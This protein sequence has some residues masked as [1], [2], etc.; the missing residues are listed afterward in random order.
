MIV[1]NK[2]LTSA[3]LGLAL[4]YVMVFNYGGCGG[5]GGGSSAPAGSSTAYATTNPATNITQSSAT[6][7]GMINPNGT[8]TN[9]YFE[10]G[11]SIGYGYS[12]AYQNTGSGGTTPVNVTANI[13]GLLPNT[14]YNFRLRATTAG[15]S[16]IAYNGANR[17][18]TTRDQNRSPVLATIGN[19][20]VNEGALLT[21]VISATDPDGDTMTYSA[22]NM[23]TGANF[24]TTTKTF[25]WTPNYTQAA[26]YSIT[27]NVFDNGI[28]SLSDNEQI[29]IT[30]NN[31]NGAPVLATIGNKTVN[32]GSL[33]TFTV[34]AADP[35]G[36]T[37]TYSATN[38][39]TGANLNSASGVFSWT[40]T[41]S[42]AGSFPNITFTVTDNGSP[43]LSDSEQITITVNNINGAPILATIGNKIGDAGVLL[44]FTISATDP[45]GDT[46]TYSA[47]NLPTGASFNP[48]TRTFSWT[49]STGQ[50]DTNYIVTFTATDNGSPNLSASKTIT[51]SIGDVNR[52]PDLVTIGNQSVNEGAL[53]T[54]TIS[55]TDPDTG[56]TLTYSATGLPTGAVFT[57]TTRTFSWTPSYTQS[58]SYPNVTFRVTDNGTPNL[59]AEEIITITVLNVNGA[60]VLAAIG[61]QTVNE[62]T[63][64]TFTISAADSDAGD[65]LT[66]SASNL[67]TGASFTQATRTFSWT[68]DYTQAGSYPNVT[69]TVTDNGTPNLSDFEQITI[70]VNNVNRAPVLTYIGDQTVNEGALLTFTISATDPDGNALTYSATNLP[71][72]ANL[73]SA[74]GVFSWTPTY[75]QAGS[76]PNVTFTVTDNGTSNL[77]DS[78]QIT[79]TVNNV[80]APTC[81][82]DAATNVAAT[83]ATLNGTVN[84]NGLNVSSCYFDYGTSTSYGSTS[85]ATPSPGSGT[86]NVSV[87]ANITS[88]SAGTL[89]N[90]RV[91]ATSLAGTTNGNNQTFTTIAPP[92]QV[93][94]SGR[95]PT[96]GATGVSITTALSW[97]SA[98]G[99]TS[100]NVYF[101]TDN[102]PSNIVNG[103]NTASTTYNPGTLTNSTTY[104]WRI[105]STN[106]GGTTAGIVWSFTTSATPPP[107]QVGSPSPSTGATGVSINPTLSWG[108]VSGAT[109][110]VYFGTNN[111]PS[112]IVNGTNTASTTYTP[113]ALANS[114]TYYWRI[115]STNAGGTT[116]GIVWSF[117]TAGS[118]TAVDNYLWVADYTPGNVIRLTKSTY[119]TTNIAVGIGALGV[120]VDETYVWVTKLAGTNNVTRITK[121]NYATTNITAGTN[122]WGVAVDETYCWVANWGSNNVTR[123]T[124]SNLQ[125]ATISLGTGALPYGVAVDGTYVWVAN[126]GNSSVTRI[127]KS[128]YATTTIALGAQPNEIAVDELYCWV[129]NN[130]SNTVTRITKSN[131][132]TTTITAVGSGP[133]GITVDDT[134]CWVSNQDSD[135]VTRI[136]KSNLATTN[137]TVGTQPRGIAVDATYCWTVNNG[138]SNVTRITKSTSAITNIALGITSG[139]GFSFGD[140]TGYAYDNYSRVP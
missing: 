20:T 9:I 76:F 32:E 56:D 133:F 5:G 37:L 113:G 48:T 140:M 103:T 93:G 124:K 105:D 15:N 6:L 90:F 127:T 119:A 40:P 26:T 35:D 19:K 13:T 126:G 24:D 64:L 83:S 14:P 70:T 10:Y 91:V 122:P 31:V 27:F 111:P 52:P 86:S 115:D 134:Y 18:F 75:S 33:L 78:E 81:A 44:T 129:T 1:K 16:G 45:E 58:G 108:A 8:S 7:N 66:Y 23:P 79:I 62:N 98:T 38:L 136:T 22:T 54:F 106:V 82:T 87:S 128:N 43:N 72:G 50:N 11:T 67:P 74:T 39:P 85:T 99:A 138:S 116:T 46:I 2:W 117:T 120:A 30:V 94:T 71:S 29:T 28:P 118:T 25:S 42:Q 88:L 139:P 55:A 131:S 114:T 109:Y 80:S 73:N 34:S 3:I 21:F 135:N 100:Y 63:S 110:N 77:S 41:Y 104:Y 123:I 130:S 112:N 36:N 121:S 51:I 47:T 60:P 132:I 61:A 69:F 84:P 4:S 137:I 107:A 57:P 68:P 96:S 59:T 49:P 89:Y 53:L 95:S 125:T 65:T 97:A 92:D 12:T 17:T 101:G 102:P